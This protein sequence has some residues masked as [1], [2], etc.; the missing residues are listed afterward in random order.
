MDQKIEIILVDE[1]DNQIGTM[2]KMGAH[3]KGLL[4][5]CFSIFIFNSQGEM[6]LQK[7]AVSKYHSGGLWTNACCS[8]P[9]V[10]EVLQKAAEERLFEEMGI[11]CELKEVFSFTY[12]AQVGDLTEHEFDHVFIGTFDG[13]TVINPEEADGYKWIGLEQLKTDIENYP[14]TYTEWFKIIFER[15]IDEVSP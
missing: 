1:Q 7:R 4:H 5:R 8:H 2:E 14:E 3:Q 6:L 13:E 10:G 15:A 11:R 12:Q 9:R